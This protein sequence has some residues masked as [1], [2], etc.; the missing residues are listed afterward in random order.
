MSLDPQ[1]FKY[2]SQLLQERSGL[3]LTEDKYYLLEFRLLPLLRRLKLDTISALVA[4]LKLNSIQDT[5]VE[6]TEAMTTNETSFFRDR[7]PFEQFRQITLPHLI[8]NAKN[9]KIRIWSAACST[10]QEPYSLAMCVLEEAAKLGDIK[11]EIIATD[12][13]SH[14]LRKAEDGYYTQFEVQ[15][16]LPVMLMV[17]YFE[18][19]ADKWR[20]RENVRSMVTYRQANLLEDM[21]HLG[22]FDMIFCR[23]VL[24]YFDAPTKAKVLA[25]LYGQTLPHGVLAIGSAETLYG[26]TDKFKPASADEKS[27][28]LYARQ[29]YNGSL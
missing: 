9:K 22:Q 5:L 21:S 1:D 24:V 14:L 28:G 18:Q 17:K 19:R 29:E 16:G 10:G 26:V 27:H 20:I 4:Q 11:V 13:A 3:V 6:I 25:S 2:L 8:K 15:R 23:N 7:K 12:L